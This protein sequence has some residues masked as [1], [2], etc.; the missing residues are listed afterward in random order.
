MHHHTQSEASCLELL[1]KI[2]RKNKKFKNYIGMGYHGTILPEVIQRNL[3][4]NPT[5]YTSYTPYQAEISQGRLESQLNFQTMMMELTGMELANASLLDEATAAAEA[6]TM[7]YRATD[8]EHRK[9]FF[10]SDKTHPQT[11]DVMRGRSLSLGVRLVVGDHRQVDFQRLSKQACGALVQYPDTY[12]FIDDFEKIASDLH[13]NG[14][15]LAVAADPLALAVI[16]PPREW[17]ADVCIGTTQ[18]FGVPMGFGG[19]AAAYLATTMSNMRKMP[20]RI[21]GVSKDVRGDRCF[22]MTLQTREQHI[23]KDKATSNICTAQALLAN[24]ASMYGV[25]H[26]PTGLKRIA[27]RVKSLAQ[28]LEEGLT[29]LGY[30]CLNGDRYFDTLLISTKPT[31]SDVV[32]KCMQQRNINIRRI[33][34]LRVGVTLDETTSSE[35]VDELLDAFKE[36]RGY[37]EHEL[38]LNLENTMFKGDMPTTLARTSRFMNQQIFNQIQTETEMMRYLK[39]LEMKDL[40]LNKS[41]IPLGSCTMKLNSAS[42]L[43]AMGWEAFAGMHPFAPVEQSEG[44]RQM[45]F[46]LSHYLKTITEFDHC[47]LQPNSGAAGEYAGLTAIK[48]YQVSVGE[49]HRNICLIPASAHGTNPA[50]AAMA[51]MKIKSVPFDTEGNVDMDALQKLA[52]TH[53]ENL[54]CFM[55]TYPSTFGKFEEGIKEMC[56]VIHSHGGQVYMDGANMNA[57]LGL[58]SPARIGA[59]VCH[60]NLHKTFGIPHGGGGPGVGPILVRKHLAPFLPSHLYGPNQT[61]SDTERYAVA[62]APYGSALVLSISWMFI[63]MLGADGLTKS[64]EYAILNANYAAKRLSHHYPVKYLGTKGRCAHEFI[65]DVSAFKGVNVTEE[66]ICK[67]LMDYGFHG[68]TMSWPVQHSLMIE[69]TESENKAEIDRFCDALICIRKEI[70]KIQTGEWPNGNNPLKNAPHT[71]KDLIEEPW[72]RPYTREEAC[73][74]TKWIALRGKFWPHVGRVNNAYGDKVLVCDCGDV[75]DYTT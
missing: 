39:A 75:S 37:D 59:D 55:I 19:P 23:R 63:T 45:I 42:S 22:R 72:S 18:R 74:P 33:K 38:P 21:I 71:A 30:E 3:L 36:A 27:V 32:I 34:A 13:E 2:S 53:S 7:I 50:S 57:Q 1:R 25:Y 51:A 6:M 66:D 26:G 67:R 56:E 31:S 68:P 5:W 64:A 69:P 48:N 28:R 73:Y 60:L 54:S 47:S 70:A 14:A 65:L 17:G 43:T 24:I 4:E 20:G 41:M 11:I 46:Q 15:Q 52:E 9:L 16:R 12:G 49:G 10:V 35:D 40:G 8:K 29:Q 58:T 62:A 44:Y 61:T